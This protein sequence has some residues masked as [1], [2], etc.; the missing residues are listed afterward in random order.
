M[1][2]FFNPHKEFR[3]LARLLNP[4]GKLY[5]KTSLFNDDQDFGSWYYKNDPTH[6]FLYSSESL[7]WIKDNF[8]LKKLQ[9]EPKLITFEK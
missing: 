6:V 5:C 4:G 7:E 3:L 9:I 8:K 2:H 1:E